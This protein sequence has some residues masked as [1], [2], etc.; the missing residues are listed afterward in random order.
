MR[1]ELK[2]GEED[3]FFL[4]GD[5]VPR[6]GENVWFPNTS[7]EY[8][9]KEVNWY[10]VEHPLMPGCDPELSAEVVLEGVESASADGE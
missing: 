5:S 6:V 10:V 8:T 9:V 1:I 2:R 4:K 7:Q 3:Y